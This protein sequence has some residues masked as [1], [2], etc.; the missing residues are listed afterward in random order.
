[1]LTY[2]PKEHQSIYLASQSAVELARQHGEPVTFDFGIATMV[3]TP[4][5]DPDYIA[6]IYALRRRLKRLEANPPYRVTT[7]S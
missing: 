7:P 1:M 6:Q 3:A 5:S 2:H 4:T